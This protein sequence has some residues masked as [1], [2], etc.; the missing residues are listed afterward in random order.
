MEPKDA[1]AD[2]I[3]ISSQID[4]AVL[5]DSGGSVIA[6]TL[7][8]D[9]RSTALARIAIDLFAAAAGIRSGGSPPTRVDASFG[10]GSVVAVREDER[11]IVST[12]TPDPPTALVVYDLRTALRA[13]APPAEPAKKKPARRRAAKKESDDAA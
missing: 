6:S 7:A 2:L 11:V 12:T 4:S 10:E 3:E 8:D 1:L 5:C 9:G 13:T